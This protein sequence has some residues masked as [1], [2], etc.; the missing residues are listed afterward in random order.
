MEDQS[1]FNYG[2]KYLE[3][4]M[5][6]QQ[7]ASRARML[8]DYQTCYKAIQE[9]YIW[10]NPRMKEEEINEVEKLL[11]K[12]ERM[13]DKENS[14]YMQSSQRVNE[15]RKMLVKTELYLRRI[16]NKRGMDL[17]SKDDPGEAIL[18]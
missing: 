14:S 13:V 4:V 7:T 8:D 1:K 9:L 12:T 17:P 16:I 2:L 18:G 11:N 3:E 15:L 6:A 5:H 10:L